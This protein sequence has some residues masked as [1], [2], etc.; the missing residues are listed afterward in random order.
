MI[1]TRHDLIQENDELYNSPAAKTYHWEWSLRWSLKY[2]MSVVT[3]KSSDQS[4]NL[5]FARLRLKPVNRMSCLVEFDSSIKQQQQVGE[6]ILN[7]KLNS[8]AGLAICNGNVANNVSTTG[9][10]S[11]NKLSSLCY[12][13]LEPAS[14][15]ASIK[16][17][18]IT[19][20][21]FFIMSRCKNILLSLIEER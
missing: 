17:Q 3:L 11:N 8:R 16:C 6:M 19:F 1:F 10:R 2:E 15:Q 13:C 14:L 9:K 20:L 7:N 4:G 21:A 5:P 12:L 18:D